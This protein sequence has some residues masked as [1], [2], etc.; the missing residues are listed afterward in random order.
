MKASDLS[1]SLRSMPRPPYGMG[2]DPN[3]PPDAEIAGA[4]PCSTLGQKWYTLYAAYLTEIYHPRFESHQSCN[5]V[6]IDLLNRT[7]HSDAAGMVVANSVQIQT[8]CGVDPGVIFD[9]GESMLKLSTILQRPLCAK[10]AADCW[11][12]SAG[13]PDN[14]SPQL[15]LAAAGK[16][17]GMVQARHSCGRTHWLLA[18]SI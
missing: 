5:F 3:F 2:I 9:L 10:T 8:H 4:A 18:V 17:A 14:S 1:E 15:C 12:V 13:A 11:K 16:G 6:F 7:I